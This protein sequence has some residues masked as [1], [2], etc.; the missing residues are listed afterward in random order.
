M[1]LDLGIAL[2]SSTL[3]AARVGLFDIGLPPCG[4]VRHACWR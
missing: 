4:R 3:T 2:R 1:P